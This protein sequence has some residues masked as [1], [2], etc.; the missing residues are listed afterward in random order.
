MRRK[1]KKFISRNKLNCEK[2]SIENLPRFSAMTRRSKKKRNFVKKNFL[3]AREFFSLR[4][5]KN[6]LQSRAEEKNKF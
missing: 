3:L 4:I 5:S 6:I 2:K 1:T